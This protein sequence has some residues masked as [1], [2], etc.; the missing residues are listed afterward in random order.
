MEV[1]GTLRKC[2]VSSPVAKALVLDWKSWLAQVFLDVFLGLT[3][4]GP[5]KAS[6]ST[7]LYNRLNKEK[8]PGRCC[9]SRYL[10]LW[11]TIKCFWNHILVERLINAMLVVLLPK[12]WFWIE[13]RDWHNCFWMSSWGSALLDPKKLQNQQ[14]YIIDWIRKKTPGQS[15]QSGYLLPWWLRCTIGSLGTL[16]RSFFPYSIDYIKLLILTLFWVQ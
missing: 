1:L 9:Q 7:I 16:T 11:S 2:Y 5:K 10:L 3:L 4:T 13:N 12:L 15:C 8:T 6:K 14:F